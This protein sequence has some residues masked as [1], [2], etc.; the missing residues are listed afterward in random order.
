MW[1]DGGNDWSIQAIG[2]E[3]DNKVTLVGVTGLRQDE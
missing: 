3:R 2:C 1:D